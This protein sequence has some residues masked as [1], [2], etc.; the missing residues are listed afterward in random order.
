M[1]KN[2]D[3]KI[4]S[5]IALLKANMEKENERALTVQKSSLEAKYKEMKLEFM[6]D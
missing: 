6:K 4:A 3:E 5:E 2:Y 1:K